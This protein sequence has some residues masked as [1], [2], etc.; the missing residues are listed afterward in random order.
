MLS[1]PRKNDLTPLFK[2]VR[3]FKV[4]LHT[5]WSE[6]GV[7]RGLVQ[8][9]APGDAPFT[10]LNLSR[11][12]TI[13]TETLTRKTSQDLDVPFCQGQISAQGIL[14]LRKLNLGRI[15]GNEFWTPEFW[16]RILGSNFLTL[17]FPAKEPPLKVRPR[18]VRLLKF[19]SQNS[20]QKSGQIIH[21]APLQGSF[22][23]LSVGLRKRN[24][25][26]TKRHLGMCCCSESW[27]ASVSCAWQ[28]CSLRKQMRKN[29]L[30]NLS[31]FRWRKHKRKKKKK[32][33]KIFI[34]WI[35]ESS[36]P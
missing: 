28:T 18:E 23:W 35:S 9:I 15:L 33:P 1:S 21:I 34:P 24:L 5:T 13:L 12:Y 11:L 8:R 22:G 4:R 6:L 3:V 26:K 29:V 16:T 36:P 14:H 30:G 25:A 32:N 19:T 27:P 10:G 2:E 17:L 7:L 31:A 20:T